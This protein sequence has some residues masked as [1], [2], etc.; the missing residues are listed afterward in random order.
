MIDSSCNRPLI[1]YP[2]SMG[3][4]ENMKRGMGMGRGGGRQWIDGMDASS[5]HPIIPSIPSIKRDKYH[6]ENDMIA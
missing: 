3:R 6:S 2:Y 5:N 4:C 1:F